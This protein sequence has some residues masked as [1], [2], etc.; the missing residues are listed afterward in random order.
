[1]LMRAPGVCVLH[2]ADVEDH[3]ALETLCPTTQVIATTGVDQVLLVLARGRGADLIWSAALA[4]QVRPLCCSGASIFGK[5]RALQSEFSSISRERT[6]HAVHLHGVEPCLL[7]T[8]A[9]KGSR[10]QGRVLYSPH[11]AYG[12][13]PWTSA[14]LGRLLQSYLEHRQC[15]AV[16]ASL[17]E[18][19]TLSK[20]LNRSAEVL[21]HPVSG[22][23]FGAVRQ[24]GTR[25]SVLADGCGIEAVDVV[26][27][28]SVLLNSREAR[29]PIS[30]LGM[31]DGRTR[32]QLDAAGVQVLATPD[33]AERALALS[34]ASIFIHVSSGNRLP[35]AAAQAMA[36]GVPCLVSDTPP[37]RALIRHGES[38]FVCT[39][40]RDFLEKLILLLRDRAERQRIGEAARADAERCFT[41]RHFE[42]AVLRAYGLAAGSALRALP[43]L[44]SSLVSHV[45]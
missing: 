32:A 10:L 16:T 12:A 23:F 13:S 21:P 37:H 3:E 30:W 11:L 22:V 44:P 17:T 15:A 34:R 26:T 45:H 31:A 29:V 18:A 9:L 25:P 4:A 20:L 41:L 33:D 27:R 1:M 40:E 5:V 24:E 7:G 43:S 36:A 8:C 28:L 35:L 14:L 19:Q 39:S 6:L 38:G 2:V 42:R